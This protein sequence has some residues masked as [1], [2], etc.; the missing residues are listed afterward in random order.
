MS[1]SYDERTLRHWIERIE[2]EATL[3][4]WEEEFLASIK[5]RLDRCGWL[6]P[7]QEQTLERIY[8]EKT[9]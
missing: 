9:D 7:A 5:K 4:S 6:T 1:Q 2:V 3:T 8:A